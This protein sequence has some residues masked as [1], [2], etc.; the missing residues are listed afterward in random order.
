MTKATP[1]KKEFTGKGEVKGYQYRQVLDTPN[2]YWYEVTHP[3]TDTIHYEVFKR[4]VYKP[5][6]REIYPSSKSFGV[7]AWTRTTYEKALDKFILVSSGIF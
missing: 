2:S 6:N 4:K 7:W 3:E 1:L 5:E